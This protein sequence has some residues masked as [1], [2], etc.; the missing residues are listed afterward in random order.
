MP[1]RSAIRHAL[2][3]CALV[4]TAAARAQLTA[5]P[6]SD[7]IYFRSNVGSFKILGN[8]ERPAEGKVTLSF[9]GTVLV[10]GRPKLDIQGDV[11]RE[12]YNAEN[13]KQVFFGRGTIVVEGKFDSI[14]CFGKSINAVWKGW[15]K[16]RLFGEFDKNL[17]T[18]YYWFHD[19]PSRKRPWSPYGNEVDVPEVRLWDPRK[20]TPKKRVVPAPKPAAPK[21]K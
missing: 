1:M 13:E 17:E 3:V 9:D 2:C 15:G 11:R 12:Y 21:P 16:I 19:E 4:A 10:T 6:G 20:V 14:Q 18:G 7:T 8:Q 5:P